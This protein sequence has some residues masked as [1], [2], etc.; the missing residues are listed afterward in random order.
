MLYIIH[1]L[2]GILIALIFNNPLLIIPLAFLSHFLLDMMPHWDGEFDKKDFEKTGVAKIKKSDI[3]IRSIDFISS[4]CLL[5][6]FFISSNNYNI[7]YGAFFSLLPDFLKIG[8]YTKIKKNKYFKKYL[9]FHSKI[10]KDT[11][12]II[13]LIIQLIFFIILMILIIKLI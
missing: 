5:T 11:Q 4:I 7:L 3:Y 8:Y 6:Y 9:N 2:L 12:K 13:G 10:Q 1:I